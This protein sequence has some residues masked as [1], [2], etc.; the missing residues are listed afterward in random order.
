MPP[1]IESAITE[2]HKWFTLI[3]IP[4]VIGLQMT[5]L[6][7]IETVAIKTGEHEIDI[8]YNKKDIAE[9]QEKVNF[10]FNNYKYKATFRQTT[11]EPE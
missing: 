4:F 3:G 9:L 1:K 11:E 7:K 5:I 6:G 10:L 2:F 8:K